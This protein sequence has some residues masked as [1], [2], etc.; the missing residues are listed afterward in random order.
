MIPIRHR[1]TGRVLWHA[2]STTSLFRAFLTRAQLRGADLRDADL[3]EAWLYDADLRDADLCGADLRD[4]HLDRAALQGALY[5]ATTHWPHGFMP[6]WH[7]CREV[8][9]P[10]E[11][12]PAEAPSGRGDE[13]VPERDTQ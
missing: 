7:G 4:A 3:R 5:D 12:A 2:G 11:V 10:S 9:L 1:E 8:P 6:R 13:L